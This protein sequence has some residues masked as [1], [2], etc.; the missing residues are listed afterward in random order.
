MWMGLS[1]DDVQGWSD[2]A[3]FAC[4]HCQGK[5]PC[6]T[7]SATQAR[8]PVS[9]KWAEEQRTLMS[10]YKLLGQNYTTLIWCQVTAARSTRGLS[11]AGMLFC[12]LLLSPM[13]HCRVRGSTLATALAMPGVRNPDCR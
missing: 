11:A 3:A 7:P 10:H 12:K 5:P 8:L 9:M 6:V 13:P 1:E 2:R 4:R